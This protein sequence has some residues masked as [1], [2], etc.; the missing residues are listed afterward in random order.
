MWSVCHRLNTTRNAN[1]NPNPNTLT[2][3]L[4]VNNNDARHIDRPLIDNL[5]GARAT[6]IVV[7]S[8]I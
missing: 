8:K 5:A 3:P 1:P 7:M 2:L 6:D 4:I